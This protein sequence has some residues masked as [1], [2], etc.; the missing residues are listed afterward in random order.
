MDG[1]LKLA[2][3]REAQ[4]RCSPKSGQEGRMHVLPSVTPFPS[5][6]SETC[7]QAVKSMVPWGGPGACFLPHGFTP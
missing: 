5:H 2:V 7:P 6:C 1:G 3:L 4:A